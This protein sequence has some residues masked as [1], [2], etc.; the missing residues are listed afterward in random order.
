LGGPENQLVIDGF[1]RSRKTKIKIALAS[2]G[3]VIRITESCYTWY[4][5]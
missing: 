5:E 1:G 4:S 3:L 2:R